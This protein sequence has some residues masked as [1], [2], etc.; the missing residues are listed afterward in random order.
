MPFPRRLLNEGEEVA[1][2]L[3]PHW[4]YFA[5]EVSAGFIVLAVLIIALQFNG[6][7]RSALLY[8][9]AAVAI[10]WAGWL[11]LR[12]L[13]WQTTHI[14]V[15][16]DRLILRR[17][18]LAKFGREIPLDR[19][20]DITFSQSIF[21]RMIGAGNLLIES[22]GERGQETFSA[23]PH[24][25]RL[26]QEIYRQIE[27]LTGRRAGR[28]STAGR[29][30]PQQIAELAELRDR[31]LLSAAEFEAKKHDLLDRM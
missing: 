19:V 28:M 3:R 5:K 6:D 31:G 9:F 15:T 26:Q 27:A 2:D 23:V 13:R 16:S 25:D 11:G 20:N 1:V 22:A 14:V 24:P 8:L 17:G 30:I 10:V 12:L 4:W 7:V 29:S 21:E 18:I